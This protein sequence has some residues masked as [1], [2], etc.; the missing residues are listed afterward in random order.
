MLAGDDSLPA[1]LERAEAAGPQLVVNQRV[2]QT[3]YPGGL[4]DRVGQLLAVLAGMCCRFAGRLGSAV[5]PAGS[6]TG[7][8]GYD[9]GVLRGAGDDQDDG[10]S[11]ELGAYRLG[12][13]TRGTA[14]GRVPG[15][16]PCPP[17]TP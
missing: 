14:R 17:R 11:T 13:D 12:D 1:Y 8:L 9:N 7:R 10:I 6:A 2:R 3:Q 5:G 4:G 15:A 16:G